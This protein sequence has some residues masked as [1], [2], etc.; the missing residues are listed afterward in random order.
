MSKLNATVFEY[1]GEQVD[2]KSLSNAI[3][4][5]SESRVK[6]NSAVDYLGIC[7][8]HVYNYLKKIEEFVKKTTERL[9][10]HD[11]VIKEHNGFR[12]EVLALAQKRQASDFENQT[13]TEIEKAST[14]VGKLPS[15]TVGRVINRIIRALRVFNTRVSMLEH[16]MAAAELG[17]KPSQ[18]SLDA[19]WEEFQRV[20]NQANKNVTEADQAVAF[21]FGTGQRI[22]EIPEEKNIFHTAA[23]VRQLLDQLAGY[24]SGCWEN[25]SGAGEFKSDEALKGVNAAHERLL[26]ILKEHGKLAL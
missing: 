9:D 8:A 1:K 23:S 17:I 25:L 19:L 10:A 22:I 6:T 18:T 13:I 11:K 24:S 15:E 14:E 3:K 16:R 7:V 2:I 12:G 26:E 4:A 5:Y 21:D 20:S